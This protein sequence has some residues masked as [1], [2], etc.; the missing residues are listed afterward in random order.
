MEGV[1]IEHM[2]HQFT[3]NLINCLSAKENH[4]SYHVA[5]CT[6]KLTTYDFER[7]IVV[8]FSLLWTYIIMRI[9]QIVETNYNT[10]A[11]AIECYY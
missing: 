7:V 6:P 8:F 11:N 2:L 1:S 5:I 9:R 4:K 10:H 3:I